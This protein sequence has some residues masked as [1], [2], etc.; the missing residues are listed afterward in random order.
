MKLI[1]RPEYAVI[2]AVFDDAANEGGALIFSDKSGAAVKVG[3][4]TK[5]VFA[6]PELFN[7]FKT[8]HGIE[9]GICLLG[10]PGSAPEVLG[11]KADAC[12]TYAYLKPLPLP[13]G[14]ISIK[15]LAPS[16]AGFIASEYENRGSKLE[17]AEAAELM[18]DKGVFGAFTRDSKLA[19]FIGRH[20]DGSMGMLKV[21]DGYRRRGI[22]EQLERFMICY[23]MTFPRVPHCDVYADN[24]AS[25]ALQ[26]KLGMS[27]AP[28]YTFWIM[29]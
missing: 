17:T 24:S 14:D 25:V 18:R 11:F 6:K 3:E 27:E 22:G 26:H 5:C 23:I 1:E 7:E 9:G 15:R 13:L 19:G 20:F 10:M 29:P 16:L 8:E 21:F 4:F 12:K 2:K 28:G